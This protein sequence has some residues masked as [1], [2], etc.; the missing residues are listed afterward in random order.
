MK[1]LKLL[2]NGDAGKRAVA[3]SGPKNAGPA[4]GS[5]RDGFAAKIVKLPELLSRR[6]TW[7]ETPKRHAAKT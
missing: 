7:V 4:N 1:L 2:N 5:R 6:Q 3:A